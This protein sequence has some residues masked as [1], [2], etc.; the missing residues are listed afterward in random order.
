MNL[1]FE[2]ELKGVSCSSFVTYNVC[3]SFHSLSLSLSLSLSP[4]AKYKSNVNSLVNQYESARNAVE[5][6]EKKRLIA[7][8]V[9]VQD[10]SFTPEE[11][12]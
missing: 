11:V 12:T 2:N 7:Q 5:K 10:K 9:N 3:I 1:L 8:G 4:Q 6:E